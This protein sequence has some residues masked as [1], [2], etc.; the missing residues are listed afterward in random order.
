MD[1]LHPTDGPLGRAADEVGSNRAVCDRGRSWSADAT[2]VIPSVIPRRGWKDILLRVWNGIF[3]DRML[4]NA[5]AVA[6]YTL[7]ALFPAIAALVSIYGLFADPATIA[8]QLD[9]LSGIIPGGAVQVIGDQLTRVTQ[10]GNA[11][12][13]IGFAVGLLV[14]LWST[15]GGVKAMF[16][17]LNTAH[18]EEEQRGIIKLNLVSLAFTI[19]M[20]LFA[21]IAIACL[22]AL[23]A[24][25]RFLPVFVA[26]VLSIA[27]WPVLAVLIAL[28][29][30]CLYRFGPS[31]REPRW[32]WISWGSAFAAV[33]WLVVS[34]LFSYY[35]ANFGTFNQ[36]YGS[37]GAVI[38]FM[39]WIWLSVI[40]I[41]LGAKLDAEI[42][43]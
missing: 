37:L 26:T 42:E 38:G 35:A 21:V 7:L 11:A 18:E 29:L 9:A 20:I 4:A 40:V 13:G 17:A 2:S 36:T 19:A 1:D 34:A 12:L 28:G 31:R 15:N 8:R 25:L 24:V 23:P 33:G 43:R 5:A 27:R 16:D 22:V 6:F 3:A 30:A 10:N 41:L 32:R 39:L 14:S